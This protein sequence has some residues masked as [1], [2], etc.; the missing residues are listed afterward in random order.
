VVL[1]DDGPDRLVDEPPGVPDR[2]D[3]RDEHQETRIGW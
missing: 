1:L 3:D 2:R